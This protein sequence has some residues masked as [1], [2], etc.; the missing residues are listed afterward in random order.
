MATAYI[1]LDQPGRALPLLDAWIRLH[2]SDGTLGEA[3]NE[4]CWARGLAGQMLDGALDDC[5]KAIRRDG[6]K[7]AYLDSLGL[8]QLRL[9]HYA[10]AVDAYGKA[11][12]QLSSNAWTRYGL[13]LARLRSG[14]TAGG[15]AEI[16]AAKALDKD[17]AEQFAKFGIEAM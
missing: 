14:D 17:I 13:G 8:V 4:R 2:G 15:K 7:P 3:L 16:A 1:A 11:A 6:P 9:G 12:Q 5:R 10:E